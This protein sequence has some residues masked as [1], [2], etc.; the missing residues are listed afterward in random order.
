MAKI[1]QQRDQDSQLE[2]DAEQDEREDEQTAD[3]SPLLLEQS[4][5]ST[6]C[7]TR[8]DGPR[9]CD[10]DYDYSQATPFSL[11]FDCLTI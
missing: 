8:L 2:R 3:R 5:E 11:R 9:F 7:Q 1:G 10:P 4:R 6:D